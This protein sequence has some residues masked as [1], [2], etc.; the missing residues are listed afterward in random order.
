MPCRDILNEIS[1]SALAAEL[2]A[3]A[4][5]IN[6]WTKAVN[7]A[8][9]MMLMLA[10]VVGL[11]FAPA[12]FYGEFEF[13][14]AS[15]KLVTIL[16]LRILGIVLDLGGGPMHDRIGFR[17]WKN[18]G[19]FIEFL[20]I[21]GTAGR[22]LGFWPALIQATVSCVGTEITAITAGEAKNPKKALPSAIR[23]VT[24]RIWVFYILGTFV[25]GLI[26]QSNEPRLNLN[27]HDAASSP[28]VI[29]ISNSG[30]KI[31]PS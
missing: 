28:F 3:S 18:P 26:M 10:V 16:C 9:W 19:P 6:Y 8:V 27:S 13:W 25:I 20:G 4:I 17:Y 30:I 31:L 2:S 7:N 21:Q 22:F 15:I 11:N 5:L 23:K 24:I 12:H 1:P 14:F 29:A